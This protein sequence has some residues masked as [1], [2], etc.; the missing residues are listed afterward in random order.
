MLRKLGIGLAL[1]LSS[2]FIVRTAISQETRDGH[3][4]PAGEMSQEEMMSAWMKLNAPGVNHDQLKNMAG[5]WD[6]EMRIFAGPG[7]E[8][9]VDKGKAKFTTILDG[10]FV[11]EELTGKMLGMPWNGMGVYG[12][13]NVR[14]LFT[15]FWIDS[16]STQMYTCKGTRTPDGTMTLYGEMDEPSMSMYGRVVKFVHTWPSKDKHVMACYDLA[17]GPDHKAFEISYTRAK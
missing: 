1:V 14:N 2:A 4:K 11:Q 13:D 6:V 7:G 16:T 10:R 8:P 5:E 17:A 12:Y 9:M 3:D 15:C